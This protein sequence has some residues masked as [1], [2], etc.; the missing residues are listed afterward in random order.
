MV[1]PG[2]S[3]GEEVW[4]THSNSDTGGGAVC[5]HTHCGFINPVNPAA[6]LPSGGC[7]PLEAS[8]VVWCLGAWA[9]LVGVVFEIIIYIRGIYDWPETGFVAIC[10]GFR[11]K[12]CDVLPHIMHKVTFTSPHRIH[13]FVE[14]YVHRTF[15]YFNIRS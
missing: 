2:S 1:A 11:T 10:I 13:V 9:C 7:Q 14:M 4:G 15:G 3:P 6:V 5:I 12:N 8:P